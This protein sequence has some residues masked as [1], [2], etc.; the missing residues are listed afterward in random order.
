MQTTLPDTAAPP[1]K[2]AALAGLAVSLALGYLALNQRLPAP[3]AQGSGEVMTL[4]PC[5]MEP[6][7]Y[8]TGHIFGATTLEVN[9]RGAAL[10]CAGDARPDGRGLRLFLAGRP[11][12]GSDRL[13]MVLGIA[14]GIDDLPGGEHAVS[15]TLL[16]EA[17]SRFFHAATGRCF[18][19]IGSVTPLAAPAHSYRVEGDLYCSGAIGSVTGDGSVTLGDMAYA[20]RLTLDP[21]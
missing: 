7:G 21:G 5:N 2:A 12:A 15:V 10:A 17:S 20:V 14:A 3:P 1:G 4:T 11:G 19:R 6:P 13:L 18:T 9:W 16:D 8:W